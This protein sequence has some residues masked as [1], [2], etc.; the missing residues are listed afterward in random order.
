MHATQGKSSVMAAL[1]ALEAAE[2]KNSRGKKPDLLI[3]DEL[4][5]APKKTTGKNLRAAAKKARR[6]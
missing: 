6:K 2:A 1:R 3:V 4:A 5:P